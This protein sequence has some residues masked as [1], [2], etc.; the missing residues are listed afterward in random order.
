MIKE[1]LSS[2]EQVA[3]NVGYAVAIMVATRGSACHVAQSSCIFHSLA[4]H[5]TTGFSGSWCPNCKYF[6]MAAASDTFT[7]L[8]AVRTNLP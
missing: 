2:E 4:I 3:G 8:G 6:S 5:C 1:I 7:S